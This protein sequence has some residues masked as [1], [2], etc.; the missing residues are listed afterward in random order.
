MSLDCGTQ[1]TAPH[2]PTICTHISQGSSSGLKDLDGPRAED[3][4]QIQNS[5]SFFIDT[6]GYDQVVE[7]GLPISSVSRSDSPSYGSSDEIILFRG[8]R[9]SS[10]P[11]GT[12]SDAYGSRINNS[13]FTHPHG[14][15]LPATRHEPVSQLSNTKVSSDPSTMPHM[16]PYQRAGQGGVTDDMVIISNPSH[17]LKSSR[18][19]RNKGGDEGI[20]DYIANIQQNVDLDQHSSLEAWHRRDLKYI[21]GSFVQDEIEPSVSEGKSAP[22]QSCDRSDDDLDDL[23]TSSEIFEEIG[24]ILAKRERPSGVQYLVVWEGYTAD[25]AKWISCTSLNTVAAAGMIA[26]FDTQE[27]LSRQLI[28]KNYEMGTEPDEDNQVFRNMAEDIPSMEDQEKDL[29]TMMAGMTDEQM[30]L[31]LAKQ[32]ELG[33]GSAEVMLFDGDEM[34][35]WTDK[36]NL[37][38]FRAQATQHTELGLS[39]KGKSRSFYTLASSFADVLVKDPYNGFD[40]V[41][42]DRPSLTKRLK[43]RRGVLP[44]EL[45][46][47]ELEASMLSAWDRDRTK[48]KLKKQ[49]REE[50]RAQGLLGSKDKVDMKFR[51]L[52]GM[53][54]SQ[55]RSEVKDFLMSDRVSSLISVSFPPMD[56]K[57]RKLIHEFA[58]VFN[59]K[60]KSVGG[61]RY[62]YPTLFKTSRSIQFSEGKLED[63]EALLNQRRFLPRLD[64]GSRKGLGHRRSAG[65]GGAVSGAAVSYQDGEIVGAAAPE[66]GTDN[67]GRAMLEK[68]GWSTGTALGALNNKGI[69]L[70]VAHI[71]KTTKAGLG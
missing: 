32:E 9:R 48:K 59:L 41:D 24:S 3:E 62:R 20:A 31:R 38:K 5:E 37:K 35:E 25:E 18:S 43:G 44:P 23:S 56:K 42:R 52:E 68:M 1:V 40:I 33:L 21:Q 11:G 61:G 36:K 34:E 50:L 46:D 51:Y 14:T 17:R 53:S 57:D 45:S 49:Q 8:R 69:M 4:S 66:L 30:A 54:V 65:R 60:S 39:K 28:A 7:T 58:N 67:K 10:Q 13:T 19:A 16:Q 2:V 47:S 22:V 29:D 15:R 55:M 26:L 6:N 27:Q 63:I 12:R 71:V 64:K 70:P